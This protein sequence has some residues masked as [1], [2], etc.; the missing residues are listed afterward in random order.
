MQL[1]PRSFYSQRAGTREIQSET[2]PNS[3]WFVGWECWV[4]L[5]FI[6]NPGPFLPLEYFTEFSAFQGTK[7]LLDL[8]EPQ[9]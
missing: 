1:H 7:S 5:W 9:V 2:T 4:A 3:G 8:N 6:F